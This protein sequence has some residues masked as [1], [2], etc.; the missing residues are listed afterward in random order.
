MSLPTAGVYDMTACGG[1]DNPNAQPNPD[2][3]IVVDIETPESL[4]LVGSWIRIPVTAFEQ[5]TNGDGPALINN[6][7][8]ITTLNDW[9]NDGS[10]TM[11]SWA[12]GTILNDNTTQ[13]YFKSRIFVY[14]S[15]SDQWKTTHHGY[16]GSY[17]PSSTS[18]ERKFWV[19]D[20]AD[21]V[22]R[23]PVGLVLRDVTIQDLFEKIANGVD[24]TDNPIGVSNTTPFELTDIYVPDND[25]I[26]AEK[27]DSFID[28]Q[29][30]LTE[31][32]GSYRLFGPVTFLLS[33]YG[34][35]D[36]DKQFVRNRNNMVDLYNYVAQLVDGEWYFEPTPDGVVLVIR[37]NVSQREYGSVFRDTSI[38]NNPT[39]IVGGTTSVSGELSVDQ[40]ITNQS[41]SDVPDEYLIK[42][43]NND[44]LNDI[45]PINTVTVN[46]AGVQTPLT[47]EDIRAGPL[48]DF[49]VNIA[50][51]DQVKRTSQYYE[52]KLRYE[53]Y[54]NRMANNE[55]G[56]TNVNVDTYT[57]ENTKRAAYKEFVSHIRDTTEGT[58]TLVADP[59]IKPRDFITTVPACAGDTVDSLLPIQ[60]EV[61][62]VKHRWHAGEPFTTELGVHARIN[63]DK[64]NYSVTTK[65]AR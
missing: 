43:L 21:L 62:D 56:P 61:N 16:V 7:A 45:Q 42:T 31:R 2:C 30:S 41:V 19:Y 51:T 40:S 53:P 52:V 55:A 63:A 20:V 35:D 6:T 34:K 39:N 25:T 46:S 13:P 24:D 57:I 17:G 37:T 38:Q 49:F 22:R 12:E 26:R 33:V 10:V 27:I 5:Y 14:D 1:L 8:K 3:E 48:S 11:D 47:T 23:I 32:I 59:Y 58:V 65:E 18:V 15:Q 60:Y 54:Y 64:I 4:D 50:E 28:S 44:A 36:I 9:L 29:E